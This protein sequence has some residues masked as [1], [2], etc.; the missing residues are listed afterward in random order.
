[1]A[2]VRAYPSVPVAKY[3]IVVPRVRMTSYSLLKRQSPP[4][5][6]TSRLGHRIRSSDVRHALIDLFSV[7][8]NKRIRTVL[9]LEPKQFAG[10]YRSSLSLLS[11]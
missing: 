6:S 5:Q 9:A 10:H 11:Q 3:S 1:M 7:D 8:G 2:A 4:N